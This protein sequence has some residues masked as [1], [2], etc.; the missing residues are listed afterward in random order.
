MPR[1]RKVGRVSEEGCDDPQSPAE[2]N[3]SATRRSLTP[4]FSTAI[5]TAIITGVHTVRLLFCDAAGIRR[6]RAVPLGG[7][8]GTGGANG[9]AARSAALAALA[10]DG[11]GL[12]QG[13]MGMPA[14]A[15]MVAEESGLS[16]KGEV[17]L[18]PGRC[19][20]APG[21]EKAAGK[22][23][24]A[25]TTL[26]P[27]APLLLSPV[28]PLPWMPSHAL[29]VADMLDADTGKPWVCC[30]RA[31]LRR[32]VQVAR[33]R[34]GVGFVVGFELE[35]VLLRPAQA[36][37][38]AP[39]VPPGQPIDAAADPLLL[40]RAV[41]DLPYAS[42]L[43]L[44]AHAALLDE[45]VRACS[46]LGQRVVQ[47]HSESAPGQYELAL[48][49]HSDPVAAADG[50]LL[51]K[52]AVACLAARRGLVAC[53]APKPFKGVA[54]SGMHAHVSV[55]SAGEDAGRNLMAAG[56]NEGDEMDT[57]PPSAAARELGLSSTGESFVAGLLAHLPALLPFT[58]P[59]A[60]SYERLRP[61][62][63][64]GAFATVGLQDREA[65]LRVTAARGAAA[66]LSPPSAAASA[67]GRSNNSKSI[68]SSSGSSK[69][70]VEV[71][72]VD[73]TCNPHAALAALLTAGLE[74]LRARATLPAPGKEGASSPT[75]AAA[76][77]LPGSLPEALAA[78]DADEQL[79]SALRDD[80]ASLGAA[81]FDALVGVRR[82][83]ARLGVSAEQAALRY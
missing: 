9:K 33:D 69:T 48:S 7:G 51:A 77:R 83:E 76:A 58:A 39:F 40:L 8:G 41:D 30:P 74:G 16:P 25:R 57:P 15:D 62:C 17:R 82:C 11:V 5:T 52:E 55:V 4:I 26:P 29:A 13:A 19:A 47:Y 44:D 35:F 75:P 79:C 64:A 18:V 10:T 32:V 63:W 38:A 42:S 31:A 28:R 71:K 6:A 65:P 56:G 67:R 45:M 3:R 78:L 20:A 81:L 14:H 68:S 53:F 24:A 1:S 23:A 70:N 2:T 34:L 22:A 27:P 66:A 59:S 61:G 12:T 49:A 72:A 21:E 54:G 80:E 50:L 60:G 73:A 36:N 37:N 46:A 43:G